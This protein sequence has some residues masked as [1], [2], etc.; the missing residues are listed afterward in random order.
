MTEIQHSIANW[1]HIIR[2][3]VKLW[4]DDGEIS[5]ILLNPQFMIQHLE[6]QGGNLNGDQL[7]WFTLAPKT[8]LKDVA[9]RSV[10]GLSNNDLFYFLSAF[11]S[12][13]VSLS[14][15]ESPIMRYGTAETLAFDA[16]LATDHNARASHPLW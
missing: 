1:T 11:S 2:L 12:T 8:Y 13:V 5:R 14:I 9:L 3:S 6:L 10:S 7:R 15:I 4:K 16:V